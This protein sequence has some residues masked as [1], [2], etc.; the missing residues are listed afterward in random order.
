MKLKKILVLSTLSIAISSAQAQSPNR[1]IGE[2]DP[3]YQAGGHVRQFPNRALQPAAQAQPLN[4][5]EYSNRDII[6]RARNLASQRTNLAVVM[7]ERGNIIFESY[8]APASATAPLFS[9]SVSKSLTALTVGNMHCSGQIGSLD[10]PAAT[11][12]PSLRG[13]VYGEATVKNLLTM[14]SGAAR[15]NYVGGESRAG[16]LRSIMVDQSYTTTRYIADTKNRGSLMFAATRSGER[17][18][19]SNTDTLA[20]GFIAED[21]GG[22]VENFEKHIW[23]KIGAESTGHWM[24]DKDGR[25]I[26]YAGF[27]ATARDW[28]R[29]AQFSLQQMKSNDQCL[30]TF[31]KEAT[32]PQIPNQSDHS[33]AQFK[34][35]G[36]QIWV[37]TFG[38]SP[39]YWFRGYAGQRI[40]IDP[41]K[42]RILVV[43]SWKDDYVQQIY[44]LFD[45]WQKQ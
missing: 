9:F 16:A 20:L 40:G 21:N 23:S 36:Y 13:T 37:G 32:A 45:L 6:E 42:E 7:I 2:V 25:A 22:F 39:S 3:N 8:R 29:L 15:P 10:Q 26:T 19:Y 12:S 18:V 43:F 30:S 11:Y 17:F 14:S 1:P 38:P 34:H 28:A 35:Y 31:M 44:S 41:D 27:N 4:T 24:L 33:A 5:V